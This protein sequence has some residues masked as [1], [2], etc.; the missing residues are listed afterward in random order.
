MLA[1]TAAIVSVAARGSAADSVVYS[2]AA[3]RGD[4][5][6]CQWFD[7]NLN[8][9]S[10]SALVRQTD[11]LYNRTALPPG[12]PVNVNQTLTTAAGTQVLGFTLGRTALC[13]DAGAIRPTPAPAS[14]ATP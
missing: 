1:L 2:F 14:S 12:E 4:A 9:R 5:A 7:N 10:E 6:T 13:A 8:D 11:T 3:L